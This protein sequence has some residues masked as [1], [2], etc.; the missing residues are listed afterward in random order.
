M[1]DW[2]SI[3]VMNLL[4]MGKTVSFWEVFRR[5]KILRGV[6]NGGAGGRVAAMEA[7]IGE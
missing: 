4:E 1:D 7:M 6:N 2:I 5:V 3:R